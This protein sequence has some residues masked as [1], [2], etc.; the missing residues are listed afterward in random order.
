MTTLLPT[1][2][3][4]RRRVELTWQ[5]EALMLLAVVTPFALIS[6]RPRVR[7]ARHPLQ[8]HARA[9]SLAQLR[10]KASE[11]I[12]AQPA[13]LRAGASPRS[14]ELIIGGPPAEPLPAA[15]SPQLI[16]DA[17]LSAPGG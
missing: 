5:I 1:M 14:P 4:Q 3:R 7:N 12:P 11:R 6:V 15:T 17:F 13:A 16:G 2:A 10:A 9:V 8:N